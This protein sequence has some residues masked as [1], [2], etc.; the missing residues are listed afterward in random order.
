MKKA[1]T[2]SDTSLLRQFCDEAINTLFYD[3][4]GNPL[5][6]MTLKHNA[7]RKQVKSPHVEVHFPGVGNFL[8]AIKRIKEGG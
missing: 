8:I 4:A 5:R 3:D 6:S 7:F 1:L 2:L